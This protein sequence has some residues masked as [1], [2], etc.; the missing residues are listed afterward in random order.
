MPV[1]HHK[2]PD[3]PTHPFAKPLITFRPRPGTASTPSSPA[4]KPAAEE[5]PRKASGEPHE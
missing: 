4:P 1:F 3:D 2:D 5:E